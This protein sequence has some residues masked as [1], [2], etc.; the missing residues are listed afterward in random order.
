MQYNEVAAVEFLYSLYCS[1]LSC[2]AINTARCALSTI[3][4]NDAVITIGSSP[5]VKRI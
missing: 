1:G 2:S 5:L 3:L 4:I